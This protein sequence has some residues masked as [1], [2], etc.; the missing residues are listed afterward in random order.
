[1]ARRSWSAKAAILANKS[2]KQS[3]LW[4]SVMLIVSASLSANE[5]TADALG[6]LSRA[7]QFESSLLG[8]VANGRSSLQNLRFSLNLKIA[9]S[10]LIDC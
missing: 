3:Y 8:E 1:M 4:I 6:V 7:D 9:N 10:N 2:M 5:K